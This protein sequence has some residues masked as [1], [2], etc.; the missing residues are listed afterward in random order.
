MEFVIPSQV[1]YVRKEGRRLGVDCFYTFLSNGAV[2]MK[3]CKLS[4]WVGVVVNSEDYLC[5]SA[6]SY[7]GIE[8]FL[9]VVYW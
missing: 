8:G 2:R 3:E 7:A 6:R 4:D 5:S 9:E 1:D